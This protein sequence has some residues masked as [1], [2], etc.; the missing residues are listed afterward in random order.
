MRMA[1][2]VL[3]PP[4]GGV[5]AMVT[6]LTPTGPPLPAMLGLTRPA[7]FGL[8]RGVMFGLIVGVREGIL[9]LGVRMMLCASAAGA[10]ARGI[11]ATASSS[12]A[13]RVILRQFTPSS[14]MGPRLTRRAIG[15]AI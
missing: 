6:E 15:F 11:T 5:R 7:M 13:R 9:R 3:P 12:A 8:M 2:I 1:E 10:S 14:N 4:G